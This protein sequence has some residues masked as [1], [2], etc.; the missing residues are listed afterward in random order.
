MSLFGSDYFLD[1]V[2]DWEDANPSAVV[3]KYNDI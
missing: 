2:R 3:E 1:L